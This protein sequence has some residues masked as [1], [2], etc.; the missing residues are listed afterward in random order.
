MKLELFIIAITGFF[1]FNTYYEGKYTKM[2]YSYKKHFQI[3]FFALVGI[4]LYLLIKKNPLRCKNILLHANNVIKYMPIDKSSMDMI[5]PII[6]FTSKNGF[7]ES[8][9]NNYDNDG[10]NEGQNGGGGGGGIG[11]GPNV[12]ASAGEK[13]MMSSGLKPNTKRSV[14]ETK[15]KYVAANQN[16]ICGNCKQQ[17]NAY[18]EVDHKIRLQHGGSNNVENLVA[19][20]PNC[21][22]EKTALESM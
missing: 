11:G 1:I 15:K 4:S 14:S 2:I 7:N 22:R 8:F 18:F 3:A 13:R 16:W 5:S 9:M 19:L 12:F 6:D 10:E 20:C 21:H 17:L